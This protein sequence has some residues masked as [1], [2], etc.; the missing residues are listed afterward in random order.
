MGIGSR[1]RSFRPVHILTSGLRPKEH[2]IASFDFQAYLSRITSSQHS[3][4]LTSVYSQYSNYFTSFYKAE[5]KLQNECKASFLLYNWFLCLFL[6]IPLVSFQQEC[7][8]SDTLES[9]KRRESVL[10]LIYIALYDTHS[11][12]ESTHSIRNHS[13]IVRATSIVGSKTYYAQL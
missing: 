7:A 6:T 1:F 10:F 2:R 5:S 4:Y 8:L 11:I 3:N 13:S 12:S 9:C